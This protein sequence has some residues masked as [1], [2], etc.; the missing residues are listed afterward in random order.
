M[1]AKTGKR[2]GRILAVILAFTL[3]SQVSFG[4]N[5]E[6]SGTGYG[7]EVCGGGDNCH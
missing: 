5:A 2:I 7:L 1:K 6:D 3:L 4:A